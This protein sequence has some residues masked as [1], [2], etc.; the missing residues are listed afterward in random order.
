[1]NK[2]LEPI[3]LKILLVIMPIALV[4]VAWAYSITLLS[5]YMFQT[6]TVPFLK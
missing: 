3:L 5:D 4:A 6:M 2:K 1:M